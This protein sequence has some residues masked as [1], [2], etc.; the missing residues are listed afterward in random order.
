VFLTEETRC[1]V[2]ELRR[3]RKRP[4]E[5]A[6]QRGYDYRWRKLSER[7]RRLQPW[8][9]WCGATDDLTTDHRVP[10][11]AGGTRRP[12]LADVLVL[13]RPCNSRK[14]ARL[15][16]PTVEQLTLDDPGMA[17]RAP[18]SSRPAPHASG[19]SLTVFGGG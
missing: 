15:I 5:S 17:P 8:C 6:S 14:G 3:Q 10:L 16:P 18:R 19:R 12:T 2:C 7:A 4:R 9:S 13:C 1:V 11:A